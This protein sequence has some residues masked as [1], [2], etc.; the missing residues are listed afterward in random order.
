[1]TLVDKEW[2]C[3]HTPDEKILK[4]AVPL[5]VH[6]IG[7][8]KHESDEFV[9]MA[10]YFL[11]VDK[12]KQLVYACIHREMHLV[13]GL[14]ANMLVGKDIIMPKSIMIDL[15][16]SITFITSC[17]I[18]IAITARERSQPLRK[19]LMVDTTVSLPPNSESLI[20]VMHGT[21]PFDHDFFFQPVQQPH[22]TLLAH[23]ISHGTRK[24]L[25]CNDSP[26]AV[27]IPRKHRLGT[28]TEVIY[29]NCFQAVF[30]PE[31]AEVPPKLAS[32]QFN[33]HTVASSLVD[34][35]LETKWPN[36]IMIYDDKQAV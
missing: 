3:K 27:L 10:I 7:T 22:L 29:E 20:P 1:M 30:D 34:P 12:H 9:S 19:K 5:R 31:A 16:N 36:G 32:D 25:V 26:N 35:S 11:G 15:A 4:M 2:L 17:N 6:G 23:L 21:L 33:C 13:N 14:K 18:R 8:S 24:V 28:V